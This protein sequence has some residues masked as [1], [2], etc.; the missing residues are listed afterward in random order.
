MSKRINY[1]KKLIMERTVPP[2]IRVICPN[3]KFYYNDNT[4]Y[5]IC[6][7]DQETYPDTAII[8]KKFYNRYMFEHIGRQ[9]AINTL[10]KFIELNIDKREE[11]A[12]MLE[13]I[14]RLPELKIEELIDD[15]EVIYRNYKDILIPTCDL[16]KLIYMYATQNRALDI[17]RYKGEPTKIKR[18][19]F[20]CKSI[21]FTR[22][23]I[24]KEDAL[25]LDVWYKLLKTIDPT[26][27]IEK[28]TCIPVK[29]YDKTLKSEKFVNRQGDT[30]HVKPYTKM[31]KK[32]I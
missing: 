28:V 18:S 32:V 11:I 13:E 21:K 29:E 8:I 5:L 27:R 14:A 6:K 4:F 1:D 9:D 31:T 15:I 10:E 26:D 16:Y 20:I 12:K 19:D 24:T 17:R 25:L 7:L 2:N 30:I 23:E 22:G 3:E